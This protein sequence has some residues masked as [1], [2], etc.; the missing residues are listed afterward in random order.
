MIA[1]REKF[2]DMEEQIEMQSAKPL[3]QMKYDELLETLNKDV[4]TLQ[5]MDGKRQTNIK[6]YEDEKAVRIKLEKEK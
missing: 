3:K 1:E 4:N 6:V 5:P 2:L